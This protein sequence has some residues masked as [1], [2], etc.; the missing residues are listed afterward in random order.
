MSL[1][2]QLNAY[3]ETSARLA[4]PG[5]VELFEAKIRELEADFASRQLLRP[6]S[7]APDFTLPNATGVDVSLSASLARGPAVVTF[8]RGGWCP[9][10]NL[11]LAAFQQIQ[12]EIERLT[13]QSEI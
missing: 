1:Q 13:Q 9:Y 5:R 12:P 2:Q 3:R 10:C 11:Q 7:M 6:G 4:A 8:Y